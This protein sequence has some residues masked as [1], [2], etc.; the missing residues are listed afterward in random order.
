M[1]RDLTNRGNPVV[2]I[3]L[4]TGDPQVEPNDIPGQLALRLW[5]ADRRAMRFA[6]QNR[7]IPVVT[8][9]PGETLDLALAP[10]LRGRIQGRTR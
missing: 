4:P 2:V 1:L 9:T 10:L 8:H 5:R 7:G 3:E 6:L